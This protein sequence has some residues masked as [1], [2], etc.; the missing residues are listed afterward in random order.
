M[1]FE[2]VGAGGMSVSLG[3]TPKSTSCGQD[4]GNGARR[5]CSSR[6]KEGA[7]N[8]R[9]KSRDIFQ[10]PSNGLGESAD[11]FSALWNR[12]CNFEDPFQGV[13]KVSF[14]SQCALSA[15]LKA[16]CKPHGPFQAPW[17]TSFGRLAPFEAPWKTA[18]YWNGWLGGAGDPPGKPRRSF[19]A[20]AGR[21]LSSNDP[22][23]GL[24]KPTPRCRT[25][26]LGPEEARGFAA[27]SGSLRRTVSRPAGTEFQ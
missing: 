15:P 9:C 12:P 24:W 21:R 4:R 6:S 26:F 19:T 22:F 10:A 17:K 1:V 11:G 13:W 7:L 2:V 5:P 18:R 23:Q 27:A 20:P 3:S 25:P 16:R 8:E 14:T